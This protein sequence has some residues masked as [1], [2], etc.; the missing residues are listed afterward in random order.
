MM[1]I[2]I[3]GEQQNVHA[4][5]SLH[6]LID[7]LQ[8]SKKLSAKNVAVVVNQAVVPRREWATYQLVT[9]DHVEFFS[10]VA[11]G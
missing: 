8:L 10:A 2:T 9:G 3:N 6:K 1:N 4:S 7:E 5:T 11:G